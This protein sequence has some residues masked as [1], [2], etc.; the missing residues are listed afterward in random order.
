MTENLFFLHFGSMQLKK[1]STVALTANKLN[2]WNAIF[3]RENT[4]ASHF[5]ILQAFH[6]FTHATVSLTVCF[7]LSPGWRCIL[8]LQADG[9]LILQNQWIH[10][11]SKLSPGAKNEG[12][13]AQKKGQKEIGVQRKAGSLSCEGSSSECG[14]EEG[15]VRSKVTPVADLKRQG[16]I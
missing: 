10:L 9:N 12:E 2:C 15:I 11:L 14:K 13:G 8:A 4:Q 1:H 7:C 16:G 5:D 6:L 3:V